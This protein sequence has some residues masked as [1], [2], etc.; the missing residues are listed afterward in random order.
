MLFESE[1]FDDEMDVALLND[2]HIFQYCQFL[3]LTRLEERH[4]VTI[5][6]TFLW[7]AFEDAD[8]YWTHFNC[9]IAVT[10]TF[11]RCT[12]RG[13][14]FSTCRFVD[15]TFVDCTFTEN[16]LGSPCRFDETMWCGCKQSGC[17]GLSTEMVPL[18]D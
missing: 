17:V 10:C 13:V 6:A 18:R 2:D 8:L 9:V 12:F 15:C 11:T 7:C 1:I 14:S 3:G 4:V 16:N 5:D